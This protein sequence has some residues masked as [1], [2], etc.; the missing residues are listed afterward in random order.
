MKFW[1]TNYGNG[2]HH[3]VNKIT[4]SIISITAPESGDLLV[5]CRCD[6]DEDVVVL[7]MGTFRASA[8]AVPDYRFIWL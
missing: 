2:H 4:S 3:H 1:I 7:I 8:E 5:N 6:D